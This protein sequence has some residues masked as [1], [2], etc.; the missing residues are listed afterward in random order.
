MK[1]DNAILPLTQQAQLFEDNRKEEKRVKVQEIIDELI[2]EYKLDEKRSKDLILSDG[3]L[4]TSISLKKVKETLTEGA[5]LL[6]SAQDQE[7]L[8]SLLNPQT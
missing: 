2:V 6:K 8:I 7:N 1:F 3:Y 5:V 4:I